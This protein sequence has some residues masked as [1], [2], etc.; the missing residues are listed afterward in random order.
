MRAL[1]LLSA[2]VLT[3]A[4]VFATESVVPAA[5]PSSR[6]ESL[7]N[8]SPFALATPEVAPEAPKDSFTK[9]W[10]LTAISKVPDAQGV[11]R[12]FVSIMTRDQTQRIYLIGNEPNKDGVSIANVEESPLIG[13]SK[14]T[15]KKGN[16]FGT[17]EFDQMLI[18]SAPAQRGNP[19]APLPGGTRMPQ[20]PNGT[21]GINPVKHPMNRPAIPRPTALPQ[22]RNG[23]SPFP[24]QQQPANAGEGGRRRI[25]VINS[26]P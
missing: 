15:L 2:L 17:V 11:D 20:V 9:D 10:V 12:Y 19:G 3:S 22:M 5:F 16:E 8:V 1:P 7:K 18:Q 23:A 6:Y 25:R 4:P 13:R 21:N 14:V 24:A 26:K